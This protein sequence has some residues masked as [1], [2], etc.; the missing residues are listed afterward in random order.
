MYDIEVDCFL[1][2][3][4]SLTSVEGWTD[5]T[6]TADGSIGFAPIADLAPGEQ[7][8]WSVSVRM[9]EL[10]DFRSSARMNAAHLG[11]PVEEVESTRVY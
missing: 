10:G 6:A 7:A 1:E 11:R 3:G 8:T 9:E 4:M 2:P 5:Y